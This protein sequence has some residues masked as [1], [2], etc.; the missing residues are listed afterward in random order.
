MWKPDQKGYGSK[1]NSQV[2]ALPHS[3]P[4]TKQKFNQVLSE[5][6]GRQSRVD[7]EAGI[8]VEEKNNSIHS[9]TPK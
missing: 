1:T 2:I 7:L 5:T 6:F 8:P 3:G 4:D 9:Y